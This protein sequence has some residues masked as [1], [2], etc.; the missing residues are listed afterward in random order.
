MNVRYT[1]FEFITKFSS[2][3]AQWFW[4]SYEIVT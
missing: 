1:L 2:M 4:L 3:K